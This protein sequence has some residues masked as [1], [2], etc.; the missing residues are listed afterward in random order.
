MAD[1]IIP[2]EGSRKSG[3][4]E[5]REGIIAMWIII[6]VLIGGVIAIIAGIASASSKNRPSNTYVGTRVGSGKT[7]IIITDTNTG[8]VVSGAKGSSEFYA[9]DELLGNE[10]EKLNDCTTSAAMKRHLDIMETAMEKSGHSI[11]DNER[12]YYD[13]LMKDARESYEIQVRDEKNEAFDKKFRKDRNTLEIASNDIVNWDFS[14][15]DCGEQNRKKLLR[16]RAKELEYA[17]EKGIVEHV[18]EDMAF[19]LDLPEK[20]ITDETAF[21][22]YYQPYI[23]EMKEEG[24][25]KKQLIDKIVKSVPD[26]GNIKRSEFMKLLESEMDQS[27]LKVC[28]KQA[29]EKKRISEDRIGSYYFV[30]KPSKQRIESTSEN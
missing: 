26:E 19:V 23:D 20:I 22:E 2:G 21:E 13:K 30:S 12:S 24:K 10:G 1:E 18:V 9:L 6:L 27:E 28:Y 8:R 25:R 7:S 5:L 14:T 29:L 3:I 17:D 15:C 4:I 11:P 16:I